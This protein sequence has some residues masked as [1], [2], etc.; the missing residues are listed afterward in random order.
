[1]VAHVTADDRTGQSLTLEALADIV[2]FVFEGISQMPAA[3]RPEH[4]PVVSV[5]ADIASTMPAATEATTSVTGNR[6]TP[7]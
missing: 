6:S 2:E 1:V 4:D 7:S 3:R 5:L